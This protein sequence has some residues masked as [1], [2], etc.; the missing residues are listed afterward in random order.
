MTLHMLRSMVAPSPAGPVKLPVALCTA[1]IG[2]E[3]ATRRGSALIRRRRTRRHNMYMSQLVGQAR[4]KYGVKYPA[5]YAPE[6]DATG[7]PFNCIQRGAHARQRR[8][9]SIVSVR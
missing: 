2:L 8:L 7:K 9:S 3:S 5:M 4:K 6:G 1:S